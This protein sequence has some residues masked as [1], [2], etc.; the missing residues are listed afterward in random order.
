VTGP[1]TLAPPPADPPSGASEAA[2]DGLDPEVLRDEVKF[3]AEVG[4]RLRKLRTWNDDLSQDELARL[5]GVTRNFVS[6]IERG[7]QGLDAWRLWRIA[8]ALG[9]PLGV[10]LCQEPLPLTRTRTRTRHRR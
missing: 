6:A 8:D 1:P 5:A 10:L 3:R 9:V 7:A 4:W 2:V